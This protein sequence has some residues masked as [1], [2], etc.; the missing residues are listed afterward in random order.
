MKRSQSVFL[1]L[2]VISSII[3]GSCRP[4]A[5]EKT[6]VKSVSIGVF[7]PGVM[8]GSAVYEMLAA[9]VREAV[10]EYT[11]LGNGKA[12]LII[13]EG[14]YNQAEWENKVTAMAA[15]GSYDLIIS[16]NPSLPEIVSQV[17]AKFPNQYF[18]LLDG[19][20]SGNPRVYTLR[21]NQR[22]QGYMAGCLAALV[23]QDLFEG[24]STEK[25]IGLIAA[26]E[27][28]VMNNIILPGYL[29][30]A[31]AVDP[32]YTVDFRIVG[33][34]YDAAKASELATDMIHN[35]IRVILCIAGGANE[36]V[37][38][39]AALLGAK[40]VWFDINGYGIRPGTVVGSAVMYQDKAARSLTLR[41]LG[42]HLP[43]GA[44]EIAGV[45]GGY[46]DFIQDDPDYE[47]AVSA[48][49]REQQAL[50]VEKIRKGTIT[51]DLP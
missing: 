24:S 34:W 41:Y 16:S 13:I 15:S 21:Y 17:S 49:V 3:A 9:G 12:E 11:T 19:Q 33:N 50:M 2:C 7:I 42:G 27:Y 36:G 25:R 37:V 40:I 10:D 30:G 35:G 47:K 26:Q 48:A 18:L 39:A 14:G 5:V 46:V 29:E 6:I 22:E 45:T 51:L 44:S 43:F 4:E 32:E 1:I 38:Q 20:L 23:T 28:P 31:K 8:S